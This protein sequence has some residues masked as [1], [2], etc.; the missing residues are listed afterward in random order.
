MMSSTTHGA[1]GGSKR[2]LGTP[3]HMRRTTPGSLK[4][5]G[6]QMGDETEGLLE[7]DVGRREADGS[8][9]EAGPMAAMTA[10]N[11]MT[12]CLSAHRQTAHRWETTWMATGMTVWAPFEG[13]SGERGRTPEW[14]K[15]TVLGQRGSKLVLQ[16][17]D[18][19]KED[20]T[21][22]PH[23]LRPWKEYDQVPPWLE[24]GQTVWAPFDVG[25]LSGASRGR[26]SEWR[27]ATIAGRKGS[28][29]Y[30]H[31]ED[32]RPEDRIKMPQQMRPWVEGKPAPDVTS[33]PQEAGAS[34]G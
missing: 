19:R 7:E 10:A 18:D 25:L 24:V 4:R 13:W 27:K 17:D 1:M 34:P 29:I 5:G 6:M 21:K 32:G 16:W 14:K 20:R 9:M 8:E 12:R 33:D 30:I 2:G 28:T 22:F 15:A 11:L 23:Q 31:W 3:A 26:S